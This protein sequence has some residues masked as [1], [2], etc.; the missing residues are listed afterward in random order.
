[1]NCIGA[2]GEFRPEAVKR[3]IVEIV[4]QFYRDFHQVSDD[5]VKQILAISRSAE[6]RTQ[7]KDPGNR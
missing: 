4:G 6:S 3:D 5:E 2:D 7:C 1:M